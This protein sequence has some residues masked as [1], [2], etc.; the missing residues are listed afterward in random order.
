[1]NTTRAGWFV[2][3]VPLA[4]SEQTDVLPTWLFDE[5]QATLRMLDD[6]VQQFVHAR[7][8]AQA[9]DLAE[10][11]PTPIRLLRQRL[12]QGAGALAT[13][14]LD[15]TA[16]T[17][18]ALDA[19][20]AR[21]VQQPASA[22]LELAAAITQGITVVHAALQRRVRGVPGSELT[23]FS[24]YES[25]QQL[26]GGASAHPS[27]LWRAPP[28]TVPP[29]WPPGKSYRLGP[30]VRAHWDR[31]VLP[32]VQTGDAHAAATLALLC[33]GLGRGSVDE[34]QRLFWLAAAAYFEALAARALPAID[35]AR[36]TPLRI[37]RQCVQLAQGHNSGLAALTHELLFWAAQAFAGQGEV[38]SAPCWSALR[39]AWGSALLPVWDC[40]VPQIE[41]QTH[42]DASI[43]AIADTLPAGGTSTVAGLSEKQVPT[44]SGVAALAGPVVTG[45]SSVTVAP[46]PVPHVADAMTPLSVPV[47]SDW[48]QSLTA[49]TGDLNHGCTQLEAQWYTLQHA[50]HDLGRELERWRVRLRDSVPDHV[51]QEQA[52]WLATS[53]QELA[54]VQRRWQRALTH[55]GTTLAA[56][57]RCSRALQ[58]NVLHARLLPADAI[59][60]RL[61]SVLQ[62]Q[63]TPSVLLNIQGG[64]L[65]LDCGLLERLL[66]VLERLLCHVV[67]YGMAV[68]LPHV[69]ADDTAHDATC[70][71][72]AIVTLTWQQRGHDIG[73]VLSDG[74]SGAADEAD[75]PHVAANMA[76]CDCGPQQSTEAANLEALTHWVRQLGGCLLG[77]SNP[78]VG[79]HLEL[80]LPWC[81]AV[82]RVV[83]LRVANVVLAVPAPWISSVQRASVAELELA[84]ATRR[85][86]A[87]SE[88]GVPFELACDALGL[89]S[90]VAAVSD[91][92]SAIGQRWGT[93]AWPMSSHEPVL[94]FHSADQHVAW[95]VDEVLGHQE[96]WV[97]PAGPQLAQLP[98]VVGATVLA[99]GLVALLYDPVRV[100]ALGSRGGCVD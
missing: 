24:T 48:L 41:S 77:T 46:V 6:G 95:Q 84:R 52:R 94:V 80:M 11:D 72:P 19:V 50:C 86:L 63:G 17:L 33:A 54:A 83:L 4:N 35:D 9:T 51:A 64:T 7:Q 18:R 21:L 20:L 71:A 88:G 90:D 98:G 10:V 70:Q 99:S 26:A 68:R 28:W 36:R 22:T 60:E 66:P 69:V 47:T 12:Q 5:L 87:H 97:Q 58:Q 85:W 37:L 16:H 31:L 27:D 73:V 44:V 23:L 42:G 3:P 100:S 38:A 2:D 67:A 49:H 1:M 96:V 75:V 14:G 45:T 65:M 56:Q 39:R 55:A 62:T 91:E 53:V 79:T 8:Q 15:G 81:A 93:G 43:P 30:A 82:T 13:Q 61:R 32:V 25:W 34:A 74:H 92:P 29:L 59:T 89:S 78:R 57:A 76:A 40:H